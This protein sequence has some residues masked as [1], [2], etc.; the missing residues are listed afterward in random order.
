MWF[1]HRNQSFIGIIYHTDDRLILRHKLNFSHWI[2][3]SNTRI[4]S[5]TFNHSTFIDV[6][7]IRS[8]PTLFFVAAETEFTSLIDFHQKWLINRYLMN[9][10]SQRDGIGMEDVVRAWNHRSNTQK[11]IIYYCELM[12]CSVFDIWTLF[13][14]DAMSLCVL[15]TGMIIVH[16]MWVALTLTLTHFTFTGVHFT[17][18]PH[19]WLNAF[20][21]GAGACV[22]AR[23]HKWSV[24]CR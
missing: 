7:L 19:A 13:D 10:A 3:H 18:G 1:S 21:G 16:W 24:V 6:T 12:I 5:V 2:I 11:V 23:L 22:D 15:M 14:S 4:R 8:V 17:N 20:L 9:V